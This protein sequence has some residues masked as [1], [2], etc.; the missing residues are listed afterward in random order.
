[1]PA[2]HAETKVN[3]AIA[4]PE[5]FLA[6]LCMRRDFVDLVCM[7]ASGHG[8][9]PMKYVGIVVFKR[10][11][12]D[13]DECLGRDSQQEGRP[14]S[15]GSDSGGCPSVISLFDFLKHVR[16]AGD[17]EGILRRASDCFHLVSSSVFGRSA[18][19]SFMVS[20]ISSLSIFTSVR[21]TLQ[22][23]FAGTLKYNQGLCP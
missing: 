1:V 20:S 13:A 7:S 9:L 19:P 16:D 23:L 22:I 17:W 3:P 14:M 10:D 5:A 4:H 12:C 15:C 6:A 21:L 18:H 8:G 2:R 11:N